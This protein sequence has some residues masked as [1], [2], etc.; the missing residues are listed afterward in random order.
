MLIKSERRTNNNDSVSAIIAG[1]FFIMQFFFFM[2]GYNFL[3]FVVITWIGW[4]L[5]IPGFLLILLSRAGLRKNGILDNEGSWVNTTVFVDTDIYSVIRHPF[6]LGWL[7]MAIALAFV[8][9]YWMSI[10]CMIIQIPLIVFDIICEEESNAKKFGSDY[11]SYQVR[12]PMLNV[13]KG[14]S[15]NLL[16]KRTKK[17]MNS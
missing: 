4:F 14:F 3:R 7:I 17:H 9:Q 15:R 2:Y 10:Y 12:V 11:I 5:F 16:Q 13:F 6:S 8:S 1:I